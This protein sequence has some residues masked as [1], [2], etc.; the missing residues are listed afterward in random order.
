MAKTEIRILFQA[1]QEFR[2][3]NAGHEQEATVWNA[4]DIWFPDLRGSRP[5]IVRLLLP[6]AEL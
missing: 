5:R 1:G 3:R 2:H 4:S 6:N